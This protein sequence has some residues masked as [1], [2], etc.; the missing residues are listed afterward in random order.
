MRKYDYLIVGAGLYGAVC[1]R[2]LTDAGKHCLVIEKRNHIAGNCFTQEIEGIQV[3]TY[4]GHIFH[5]STERVWAYVNRF[6]KFNSYVN[7]PIANY[8]NKLYNLPFNM[9]TF[10]QMWGVTTPDE[11]RAE[12]ARQV[13]EAG[14]TEPRNLEEQAIALVGRD[15]YEKLVKGYTEKQWGRA[16]AELPAFIIKRLPVR[17]TFDNNYFNDLYQGIPQGGYTAMVEN[18]LTS[19][20]VKLTT[21]YLADKSALDAMASHVIYTGAI[22]QYYDYCFGALEWRSLRF[23]TEI[24]DMD[25]YQGVA[26]VNYTDSETPYT[27]ILEHKHFEFGKQEKTVITREYPQPWVKGDEAYYPINDEANQCLYEK[28]KALADKEG[29]MI[30]GGRLGTYHYYDMD[31]V[32]DAALVRSVSILEG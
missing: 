14:I 28:Y 25:N 4:G 10:Y 11:A 3:H 27:R 22:D 17:F 5:T 32:I 16:C 24:L 9:N 31:K 19:I 20:E 21:D 12:I 2:E 1:A 8:H 6:A 26:A 7:S 30:F 18:M 29:N 23:E 13:K 15:I